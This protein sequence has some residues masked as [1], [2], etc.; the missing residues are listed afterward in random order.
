[1][2]PFIPPSATSL[3]GIKPLK[4]FQIRNSEIGGNLENH[5]KI[6]QRDSL[7]EKNMTNHLEEF[8]NAYTSWPYFAQ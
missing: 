8:A 1:M 5:S 6:N 4:A 2:K 7:P 3:V